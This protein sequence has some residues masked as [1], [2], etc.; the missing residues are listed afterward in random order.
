MTTS[1]VPWQYRILLSAIAAAGH[2]KAL[3]RDTWAHRLKA[4][5]ARLDMI[6]TSLSTDL[7]AH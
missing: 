4:T 1:T 7:S 3:A 2:A 5:L 6:D